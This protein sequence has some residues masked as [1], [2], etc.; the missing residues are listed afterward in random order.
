MADITLE[1]ARELLGE[2]AKKMTDAEVMDLTVKVEVLARGWMDMYERKI[3]K[4]KTV[5]EL[6]SKM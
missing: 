3:F 1:K 2:T 4:G 5:N 6:L